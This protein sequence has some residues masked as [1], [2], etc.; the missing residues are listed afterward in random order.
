[1]GIYR[2]LRKHAHE[3]ELPT[4]DLQ[5]VE[6]VI[7]IGDYVI[8]DCLKPDRATYTLLIQALA[9]HGHF[10]LALEIFRDMLA[11]PLPPPISR[12]YRKSDS[13]NLVDAHLIPVYRALFLGFSRH[14][15]RQPYANSKMQSRLPDAASN[16]AIRKEPKSISPW[17]IHNLQLIFEMFM[18]CLSECTPTNRTLFWILKGFART[19][20]GGLTK[21]KQIW[22]VLD[23]RFSPAT[24]WSGRMLRVKKELESEPVVI[25]QIHKQNT[26]KGSEACTSTRVN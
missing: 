6:P 23:D 9:Y 16:L 20:H 19:S 11:L 7:A 8:P 26:L 17:N 12:R 5:E 3:K 24:G 2:T 22:S 1:L 25:E 14:G 18:E 10:V 13:E 15:E 21:M 4:R